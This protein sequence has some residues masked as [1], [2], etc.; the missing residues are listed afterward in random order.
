MSLA[1]LSL[2]LVVL[3]EA[4]SDGGRG[5]EN[6]ISNCAR[7]SVAEMVF[8]LSL[9]VFLSSGHASLLFCTFLAKGVCVCV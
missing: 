9:V 4:G 2:P 3:G 5:A 7:M 6:V 1:A 8:A